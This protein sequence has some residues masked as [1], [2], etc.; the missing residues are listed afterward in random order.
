MQTFITD[1]LINTPE[2]KEANR[3]LR[4]CVHCGFCTA[5]CP[6]YRLLGDELD[7]PRGRIYLIK[8]LLEGGEATIKT[9]LH[10]DR[11]L[12]CRACETYCPS[13]VEYGHLLDIGRQQVESR[14]KRRPFDRLKRYLIRLILPHRN[15]FRLLL[16]IGQTVRPLLPGKLK[17]MVPGNVRVTNIK[18][19]DHKRRMI[20]FT[21]CVQPSLSPQTN[22][23]TIRLLDKVGINAFE[24]TD[25]KCCGALDYHMGKNNSAEAYIKRNI[26]LW[27]PHIE[28][29]I[30]AIVI[31]AS[32]CGVMIKDYGYI[33]RN[34]P[35][36]A[37]KAEHVASLAKDISEI[38]GN[39]EIETLK[40]LN[41]GNRKRKLVFQ[42]PCTLQ[43]GQNLKNITEVLLEKL[44]L[45]SSK[46]A[47]SH[48]CCGSAGTYSLLQGGL[49]HRLQREKINNLLA[50]EPEVIL[51]SNIGC[52]MHLQQATGVP[53]KHWIELLD[54]IWNE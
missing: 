37:V 4:S 53:V 31:T 35:Q 20:L 33:L 32:G 12:T 23:A 45:E 17:R 5:T 24:V 1:D 30:E 11:C 49:S 19:G 39:D 47:D 13:G 38:F 28:T 18:P 2:G 44:G 9:Q 8:G 42:N 3:I 14:I 51:T 6:T 22:A 43:H 52:Q 34:D 15:R 54:E 29:G 26:D 10:L 50:A 7:S 46:I 16:R 25:E 41:K 36:Y 21:G 48:L 40:S 27:W